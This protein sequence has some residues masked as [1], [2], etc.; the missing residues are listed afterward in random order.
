MDVGRGSLDEW[1]VINRKTKDRDESDYSDIDKEIKTVKRSEDEFKVFIKLLQ[2]GT[3]FNEWS[4]IQLTKS[5][6]KDIGE[7]RSAKQLRNGSLLVICKSDEQQQKAIKTNK[8]NGQRVKCSMA[9]DKNFVR[10]VI[11]GIPLSESVDSVKEGIQNVK[12][13]EAK[14]L[15]TRRNGV[16]C[17]SLSVLLTFDEAKLPGKVLIGYMSYDVKVYIPP[18]LRCF[19]CQ[20]YGHVAAICKGKQRCSKCSGEHEY[21]KC[22]EGAKLK[23]CNCGGEHSAAY[24]GCEANKRMQEVQRIKVVQG[25]SYAEA[26]KKVPRGVGVPV[27]TIKDGTKDVKECVKCDQLK[28]DTLIVSKDKWR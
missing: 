12:V 19:K 11:S 10:G 14:R 26:T 27:E 20:R 4:P 7:V 28:E 9:Y 22:E 23:C 13:R 17:D 15:K 6:H 1:K 5:L 3:T 24:G 8:L 18:P 2:E 16:I 21:G 25:V